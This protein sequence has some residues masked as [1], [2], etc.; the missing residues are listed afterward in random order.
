MSTCGR[1]GQR[2]VTTCERFGP[3]PACRGLALG[4]A[5]LGRRDGGGRGA[6]R[7]RGERV[8]ARFDECHLRPQNYAVEL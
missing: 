5:P 4:S 3:G 2:P 1:Q 7:G 6:G 8:G